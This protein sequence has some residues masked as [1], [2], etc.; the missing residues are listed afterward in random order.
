[1]EAGKDYIQ[2]I[3][4]VTR[5]LPIYKLYPNKLYRNYKKIV[6]RMQRGGKLLLYI[7]HGLAGI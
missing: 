5:A 7:N 2:A 4:T 3:V 6:R 1:M